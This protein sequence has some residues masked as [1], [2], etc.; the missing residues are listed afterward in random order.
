MTSAITADAAVEGGEVAAGVGHGSTDPLEREIFR[1][2]A[3]SITEELE[4]NITRT[5]YSPLIQES[6]DYCVSLVSADYRPFMQSEASI[7]IFVSDM[8]EVVRDAVAVIGVDTLS[9]GDVFVTN[10][11]SG[12]HL[13]NVVLGA[14]LFHGDRLTAYIAIRAHWADVGGLVPGGQTMAARSIF[15]EGTRYR[16]LR[17]MR[18]GEIVPEVLATLQAN[19]YQREALTGDMMAQLG[20][21]V[22][23]AR[24]WTERVVARWSAD[25]TTALI[26]AQLAASEA[27][28]RR[29][30]RDLPDG[31]YSD[32]RRWQFDFGGVA[33]DMAFRLEIR[34]E[35]DR[36]ICDLSGMPPQTTLPINC[37]AI[38]GAMAAVRLA[39]RYLIGGDAPTD[40]GFFAP[41]EVI[42]PPGTIVSAGEEA[43]MGFWN[44]TMPLLID[45]FVAA[46]GNTHPE[47][48]PASHFGSIGGLMISGRRESGERWLMVEGLIG[49][50]G[51]ECDADGYGP[52]KCL[53]LGNMKGI[54]LEMAEA[55]YPLRYRSISLDR[56][57]GG[58]GKYRGGPGAAKVI[59]LLA[60]CSV[61][62]YPEPAVPAK[63]L[64]GGGAG[65]L[66]SVR[67]RR[68]GSD[69]WLPLAGSSAQIGPL[70]A[71]TLIRQI[72]GGGG[73]WGRPDSDSGQEKVA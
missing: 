66:S 8:G 43:P 31:V 44:M 36:M 67:V 33:V 23:G 47:R 63:G 9:P 25:E 2:T 21:C 7:P 55:R 57:S 11:G 68:P 64:A 61:D 20:A 65:K 42:V 41:L 60:P 51:A 24:R 38:G 27:F 52:V 13:N 14:P 19:T 26:A 53:M 54:P 4:G 12:Q 40:G 39:F 16:G 37:G 72:S 1:Y 15:Q 58:V 5:A 46:I 62:T 71:G 56:E 30:I 70:P 35:G 22:L 48:V 28:A 17:L 3:A 18:A 59:E 50:L 6:Q 45:M 29:A 73:G 32:E 69:E 49:G 34:I 10:Y